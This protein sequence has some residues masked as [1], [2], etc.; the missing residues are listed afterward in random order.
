MSLPNES[1]LSLKDFERSAKIIARGLYFFD[2]LALP[3]VERRASD[4]HEICDLAY[5]IRSLAEV[6]SG[7]PLWFRSTK[8][9][10]A[11]SGAAL[12]D[13]NH[14]LIRSF[15]YKQDAGKPLLEFEKKVLTD[16]ADKYFAIK[17]PDGKMQLKNHRSLDEFLIDTNIFTSK[18][19]HQDEFSIL[20]FLGHESTTY[21]C[22]DPG[23]RLKKLANFWRMDFVAQCY[24]VNERF[25]EVIE[26]H[27]QRHRALPFKLEVFPN[28]A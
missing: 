22:S 19:L 26:F 27:E 12:I 18:L 5:H 6:S 1:A 7:I 28:D 16:A 15:K 24:F 3:I 14:L 13:F 21:M 17:Y 10:Q 9:I 4:L 2:Q 25:P 23:A 20:G 8:N 11:L